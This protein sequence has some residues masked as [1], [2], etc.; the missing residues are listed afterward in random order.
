[1]FRNLLAEMAREGLDGKRVAAGIGISEKSFRNK[2]SG[3]TE[4]TRAEILKIRNTYFR[5]HTCDYLF[6]L[7]KGDEHA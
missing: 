7:R 2:L 5:S 4:F 6:D 1:M 3:K